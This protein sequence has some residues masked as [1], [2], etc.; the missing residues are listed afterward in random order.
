VEG[1]Q[2]EDCPPFGAR[3][4]KSRVSLCPSAVAF[5]DQRS[6]ELRDDED[7][8]RLVL[9]GLLDLNDSIHIKEGM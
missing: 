8:F 4:R 1:P 2:D 9:K 6:F 7:I 3:Q 5:R